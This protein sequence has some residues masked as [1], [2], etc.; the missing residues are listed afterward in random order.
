MEKNVASQKWYVFA[1]DETDNTP[2]ISDA[3][4]I[5]AE[6]SLDGAAGVA[7]NDVNPTEIEDGYYVF[8]L[9]QAETN[10]DVI[11]ILP[12]SSTANIQVVGVPS[13]VYT[14]PPNF[15]VFGIE[16]DGDVTKANL[17]DNLTNA[18]TNGDLTATMKT[19][20]NTEVDTA[21]ADYDGPTNAEMEARTL[22]AANYFD[23]AADTVATVTDVTNGVSLSASATSAQ[24]VDDVWDEALT[25][26]S[27]N[28]A[29]SAGRRLR[30]IQDFGVYDMASVWVDEVAGTSTG[31]VD[32]EDA[33]VTN[34]ANDFDNAQ[35]VA[36]SVDLD[37]IHIQ[38]GN[39]ITLTAALTGYKVWGSLYS[40]V[41]NG[42]NIGGTKFF[43]SIS[44]S[45]TGTGTTPEF[46]NCVIGTATLSPCRF[47]NCSFSGTLTLGSAG[48]F[49]IYDSESGVAGASSPVIDMGAAVGASTLELRNWNGGI[50]LNN[51]ASG[52]VVTIDGLLGTVTLNG[53]DASVEI[54]G[55]YKSLVNNLTGSPTVNIDGAIN[56]EGVVDEWESQ[57]QTDPTGF[58]V[59]VIEV[60]GTTQTANDNG[61]D[62]NAI[63]VDTNSL[64]VTKIPDTLSLANINAEVD[65]AL[66]TAIPG[67]PTADSINDYIM[68]MKYVMVNKME[69][70]E[71]NGNTIIYKDNDT[72]E[73]ANVAAAYSTDATTTTR[74]RLE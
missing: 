36:A 66:N 68:R 3:A 52:D 49:R 58:H 24:L 73:Y 53:A 4:Q 71:A 55:T 21:L 25:A 17:V 7:S 34:R 5:T 23:P 45:G 67:T 46:E 63:L 20:V 54:R 59:N 27:H 12:E 61:A 51:L 74:K 44:V 50:T 47:L 56:A 29:T 57:S 6:L 22:V 1:F 62:I 2:K 30:S 41:L 65:T 32:G 15:N 16:S 35:T 40:I 60:G 64:N 26:G 39:T 13:V 33:T 10:A 18:P 70:T 37:M 19:S 9:T 43:D 69:I 42:Q 28:I 11:L 31:T 8:D 72:T 48:A 38:S 14:R